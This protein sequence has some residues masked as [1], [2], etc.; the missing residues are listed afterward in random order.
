MPLVRMTRGIVGEDRTDWL[1]GETHEASEHYARYLV[2]QR[3]AAVYVDAA[4]APVASPGLT[5]DALQPVAN[6]MGRAP[7][8]R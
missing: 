5:T 8:R 3:G 1:P 2:V 7:K 6:R 4:P